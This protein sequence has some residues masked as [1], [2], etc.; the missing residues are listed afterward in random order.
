MSGNPFF[1]HFPETVGISLFGDCMPMSPRELQAAYASNQMLGAVGLDSV[2]VPWYVRLAARYE[3]DKFE[4]TPHSVYEDLRRIPK[5]IEPDDD[6]AYQWQDYLF[7]DPQKAM[8]GRQRTGDCVS[9]AV[10]VALQLARLRRMGDGWQELY[11]KR[12][13]TAA[14]YA[15]RGHTGQGA[16]TTRQATLASEVGFVFEIK[17]GQYDFTDYDSYYRLG[18]GWGRSG[19][20]S[21][22]TEITSQYGPGAPKRIRTTEGVLDAFRNGYVLLMGSSLGVASVGDP[23]SR[24]SGS[25]NHAMGWSGYD[26]TP[27]ARERFRLQEGDAIIFIDQSWG[28]WNRLT[29]IPDRWKPW[30][31]GQMAVKLSD[32][33]RFIERGE[34]L[35]FIPDE[36]TGLPV[37]EP[38][39]FSEN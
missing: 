3:V 7:E 16:N 21:S 14:Y 31:Q 37:I 25:W 6:Y 22:I 5:S 4:E 8:Q 15:G 34:C 23:I 9:W 19:L 13:C 29:G 38:H 11:R 10:R 28:D 27:W 30:P 26:A 24:L 39:P 1:K 12:L 2:D 33:R 36:A 20:P 32:L 17:Y 35:C 18:M